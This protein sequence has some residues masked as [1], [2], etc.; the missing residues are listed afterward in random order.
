MKNRTLIFSI[1]FFITG[2]CVGLILENTTRVLDAFKFS[3][4]DTAN[5]ILP[6]SFWDSADFNIVE[7]KSPQDGDVQKAYFYNS[8]SNTPKP[9]IVSLHSWSANY[10]QP[11]TLA[12]LSKEND[13]NYIHPNF[14]GENWNKNACCSN[15]VISDIDA[16]IDYAIS[17]A[18]VDTTKIYVIG[19][20]G[21]GYATLS[22]FMKSRHKIKKFSAWVPLTDLVTWYNETRARKFRYADDILTC[23][24]ST[25]GVLDLKVAWEKSPMYWP[26]PI[27]KLNDSRIEIFTGVYDGLTDS[28]PIPITQ[29][30]NFYNKLLTDVKESDSSKYV[31]SSETLRLLQLKRPTVD[32]GQIGGRDIWL[33]KESHHI[34]L[35]L[36]T[37]EHEML[38]RFAFDNLTK[39]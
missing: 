7:I 24:H 30:I 21:G 6:V 37:G 28:N 1:C 20:S 4:K 16:A 34:R 2:L 12:L 13:I 33:T 36:F 18:A 25:N 22:M 29:A 32:F 17:H 19:R 23:T 3:N 26:T 38:H 15:L 10:T 39:E 14:R 9:L 27:E 5:A 11:D 31:S 8:K 35:T